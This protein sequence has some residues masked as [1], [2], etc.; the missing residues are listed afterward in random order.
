[1][2]QKGWT[3]TEDLEEELSY[4]FGACCSRKMELKLDNEKQ[5]PSN[6]EYL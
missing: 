3:L 4:I 2:I 6:Q 1:M 5:R